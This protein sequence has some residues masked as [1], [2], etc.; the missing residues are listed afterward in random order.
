MRPN[1]NS[2]MN[3][4]NPLPPANSH[5]PTGIGLLQQ[6]LSCLSAVLACFLVVLAALHLPPPTA[7]ADPPQPSPSPY[8]PNTP[9]PTPSA[10]QTPYSC[11][12][13]GATPTPTVPPDEIAIPQAYQGV[14]HGILAWE[15]FHPNPTP[16]PGT[17][18]PGIVMVHGSG[19]NGGESH[20][21]HGQ[22]QDLADHGYYV[23]S[24]NYELAPCGVIPSQQCH[25]DDDPT[26]GWWVQRQSQ[27]VEAFVT[28]LR[29]SGQVNPNKIGIVGGSSGATLAA[30]IALDTTDTNGFWPFWKAGVRPACAVMLSGA[31]DFSDR[32]PTDGEASMNPQTIKN[33]ENFT[34]SGNPSVQKSLSPVAKVKTP[35]QQEPFIPMLFIHSQFD[36]ILPH[37]QLDD[38]LCALESKS[39]STNLYQVIELPYSDL[40]SF[41]NWQS[42]DDFSVPCT[43]VRDDV[44]AFLD[45]HLK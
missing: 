7:Q 26:P 15:V 6:A 2:P 13:C 19:F 21:I 24:I 34:Q 39:I 8:C 10:T 28:A 40:H 23:V 11:R 43:L 42:C 25:A 45:S 33:L 3:T 22:A 4:R 9:T 18:P 5:Q 12:Q 32:I 30:L 16:P 36:P 20:Q 35:T 37:H 31:Y 27:N 17:L 29:D 14:G 1:P 41:H 38:M 44:I